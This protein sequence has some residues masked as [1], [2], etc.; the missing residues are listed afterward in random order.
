MMAPNGTSI[1]RAGNG[2]TQIGG[3]GPFTIS[4]G[5]TPTVGNPTVETVQINSGEC[6]TDLFEDNS[7]EPS[8][9]LCL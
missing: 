3:A 2:A 8:A 4:L 7:A 6:F 5:Q 1:F 9:Q